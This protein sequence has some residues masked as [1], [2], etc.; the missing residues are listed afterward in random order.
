MKFTKMHGA[1]NDY[2]YVN[3]FNEEVKNPCET[4]IK[5]SDRHFGVGSDGLVLIEPSEIAD[6]KMDIY[7]S[8]GSQA[9]MCGNATRCVAKYVFDNGLTNKQEISLETL[10]GIK[11][12]KMNVE[13]G[14][15]IS[16]RVNMGAPVTDPSKIPVNIT[17][18]PVVGRNL[19]IGGKDYTI[20]CVS[21]GNPHCVV[22][23]E[24]P[25][26]L[27]IEKIGP[28]F[29]NNPLFPDRINTEFIKIVD[30]NT[31]IMRVWER[32]A[33]ETLACGT[34]ACAATA[35]S[36]L[37]GYCKKDEDIQVILLGGVLA[38]RWDSQSNDMYMT[39]PASTVCTGEFDI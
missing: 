23:I 13:N 16:A 5:V 25:E 14:K 3:C 35:A 26:N 28:L 36:I 31:L 24:E 1:G 34:G 19:N 27:E 32:G 39:G 6:F 33:G 12:I 29:E 15:V 21:M 38:I 2:I 37:N 22:F 18:E 11:Y 4:A 30:E 8:D 7:N 9:K 17:G 10:S 20:T